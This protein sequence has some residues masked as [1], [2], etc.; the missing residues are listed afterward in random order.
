MNL[1]TADFETYYG[2]DYTLSKMTTEAYVRD[3]R[4]EALMVGLKVND[5]P[6]YTV[7][8]G[9]IANALS[10]LN[11]QDSAVLCH[12]AHFDGLIL[13]H[14]YGIKP[15]IWF[16]TLSMG[17]AE[18][19]SVVAKGMSLGSMSEHLGLGQKGH[20][21]VAAKGKHLGDFE[22]WELGAYRN[23]CENDVDL[24]YKIH[25][26]LYPAF[27][28]SELKLIDLT[29][30]L[31]TEPVLELDTE[32]LI[33]YK[34]AV[35]RNKEFLMLRAGVTRE[36]LTSNNKF[37]EVLRRFEIEPKLKDSP[38]AKL[39]DGTPKQTYAFAKT[40]DAMKRLLESEN[41]SV[42]VLAE[43]R[44]GVKT[45]IAETRAQRFI[46][47]SANGAACVY[48]KFWGAEQTGRHG[49]GDRT[50]FQNLGRITSLAEEDA[51]PDATVFTPGGCG[52]I[53]DP[54]AW[55]L[56]DVETTIGRFP[57][58]KCHRIGLRDAVHAPEGHLLVVGDSSNIEA[59]MACWIAGQED[60]LEKYR[61][62]DDLYCEIAGEIYG[63][64]I[65]KADFIERQLGKVVT[66]GCTYGMGKTK[67]FDTA[68][69]V[70]GL[71][72]IE[73]T[74]TDLAVDVFR[75]KYYKVVEF[76]KYLNDVVI[77]A[78]AD[79]DCVDADPLGCITT[80]KEGLVL[81]NGRTLRYPNLHQ[82]KNPDPKSYFKTEWVFD[83]REGSR[84]IK[85]RLYGGKLCENICQALARIV[86]LDQA[87]TISR[88]HKVA[89]LV[90][91]EIVCCVPE[92][93]AV[94]CKR[95]MM[96]VMSWTPAWAGGLP[97]AAEG[98]INKIY[99]LAK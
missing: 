5:G 7:V 58:K 91:D 15:K 27:S 87:V 59:R 11:I 71:E 18:L 93:Q 84:L 78:M 62:G 46:D 14:H 22:P 33:Q 6:S 34:E 2:D 29:I 28:V 54:G 67:F 98:G 56:T 95:F 16:D 83:V 70:K 75:P 73:K 1:I 97:L 42:Q 9:S 63:R 23:Y 74:I 49:G 26:E 38:T 85:T 19:G 35:L 76:W 80:V 43:A 72:E 53:I 44:L 99:S 89:M 4:F 21:V 88:R 77:P 79:G 36:E 86:V 50:N 82:R 20:E 39:P 32:L 40:D 45:S 51:F 12:H 8:G 92:S 10:D 30:R 55:G 66:L 96:Q 13:S 90:H 31:F 57:A 64:S 17:R 48:L 41:E 24:T 65:T 37:A 3:P 60:I 47:M 69:G 25:Q 81:P 94:E 61:A 68:R 52:K